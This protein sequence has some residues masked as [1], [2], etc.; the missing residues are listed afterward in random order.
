MNAILFAPVNQR[1]VSEIGM[2]L[3]LN[4]THTSL[5]R[6]F[7]GDSPT[8]L[9]AGFILA[10]F[11]TSCI[12]GIEKLLMPMLLAIPESTSSSMTCHVS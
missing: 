3:N 8:W 7:P 5:Y 2:N 4:D 11:R 1:I 12:F 10:Y 9:T 6:A